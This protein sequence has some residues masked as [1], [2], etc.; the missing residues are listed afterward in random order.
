MVFD[1]KPERIRKVRNS[2]VD[3][4]DPSYV[5]NVASDVQKNYLPDE[6]AVIGG[7]TTLEG[8][9]STRTRRP[10]SSSADFIVKDG[11]LSNLGESFPSWKYGSAYFADVEGVE[12]G[13]L[14]IDNFERFSFPDSSI[15]ESYLETYKGNSLRVAKPEP[16]VA[17]KFNRICTDS[18]NPKQS[19]FVDFNS[20]LHWYWNA[21]NDMEEV[22]R[23]IED[24]V[25]PPYSDRFQKLRDSNENFNQ[26]EWKTIRSALDN[27]EN[28]LGE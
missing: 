4:P 9:Q 24:R 14:D 26:E 8:I 1:L 3:E 19:D 16:N 13:I 2:F 21:H 28:K 27:M 25:N 7:I 12:V 18:D 11:D 6:S 5:V 17:S 22:V 20:H 23:L 10:L 15:C